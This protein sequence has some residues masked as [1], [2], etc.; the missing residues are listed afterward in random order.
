MSS[1]LTF[2]NITSK[3]YALALYE[4][5]KESSDLNKVKDNLESLDNLLKENLDFKEMILN[6]T[7]PKEEK[8]KCFV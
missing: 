7:I 2:S 8:K 6:P 4:L 1:K 3:S 5:S